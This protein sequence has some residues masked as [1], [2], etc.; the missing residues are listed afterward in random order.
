MASVPSKILKLFNC[1]RHLAPKLIPGHFRWWIC[2]HR[3]LDLLIILVINKSG[4]LYNRI[5]PPK[6]LK[7]STEIQDNSIGIR[8]T[9][10]LFT[11]CVI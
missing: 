9:D 8:D 7:I 1:Y 11:S 2:F 6:V 5:D 10:R 3:M 4:F